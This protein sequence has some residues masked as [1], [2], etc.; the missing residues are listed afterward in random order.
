MTYL[1][2]YRIGEAK[3]LI[4][5]SNLNF[6]QIALAVGYD[7]IYYFSTIFKK[8]TGMTPTEYSKSLLR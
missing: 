2:N 5:E 6:S 4:Q 1:T 8:H 7:N 3:R